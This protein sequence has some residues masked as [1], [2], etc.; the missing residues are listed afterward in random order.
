MEK[1]QALLATVART[2]A[3]DR[4]VVRPHPSEKHDTWR[5]WARPHERIEII[6]EG[7]ANSWMLAAD[8]IL[9]T[10]CTTGIEGV[11]LDHPVLS[12]T[13]EPGHDLLNQSDAVSIQ[14]ND[15]DEFLAQAAAWRA[16][17][18]GGM[19]ARLQDQCARLATLIANVNPPL[20]VDRIVTA[21]GRLDLPEV[22]SDAFRTRNPLKSLW[23]TVRSGF[24]DRQTG[25]YHRQKFPGLD[26]ADIITPIQNWVTTGVL[27]RP[28]ELARLADGTWLL[29]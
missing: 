16:L 18:S 21:F 12:F 2:D 1:L 17:D 27:K 4:I 24:R 7:S 8:A 29:A 5:E 20:A 25:A 15:A 3:F 23:R 22:T 6:Y 13:P 19:R 14:V 28:P 9:H 10:G 26:E 11:L